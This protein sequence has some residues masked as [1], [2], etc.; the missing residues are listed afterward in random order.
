MSHTSNTSSTDTAALSRAYS[1][2][3]AG[4]DV[5]GKEVDEEQKKNVD[6]IYKV[7]ESE[8]AGSKRNCSLQAVTTW[9]LLSDRLVQ[10]MVT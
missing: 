4:R 3:P 9:L 7:C 2:G 1:P 6:G 5:G 10:E 8:E